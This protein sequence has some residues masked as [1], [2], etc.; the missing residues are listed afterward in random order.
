VHNDLLYLGMDLGPPHFYDIFTKFSGWFADVCRV[1]DR[2]APSRSSPHR[3]KVE[4][5]TFC[6]RRSKPAASHCTVCTAVPALMSVA[7]S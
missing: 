6:K 5:T 1:Y 7:E 4:R 3:F 2:S